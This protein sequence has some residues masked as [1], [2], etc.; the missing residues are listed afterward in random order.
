[1]FRPVH[2]F[3][4]RKK[5]VEISHSALVIAP[6]VVVA[7]KW[8]LHAQLLWFWCPYV[9]VGIGSG[10]RNVEGLSSMKVFV[11]LDTSATK[12]LKIVK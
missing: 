12:G 9:Y 2:A 6:V 5:K 7:F 8:P 11:Y 10:T 4:S 3:V 1:M